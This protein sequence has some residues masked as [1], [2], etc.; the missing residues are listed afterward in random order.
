MERNGL[1]E[2]RHRIF[3]YMLADVACFPHVYYLRSVTSL[4]PVAS[5][6]RCQQK[7]R[8]SLESRWF[9]PFPLSLRRG[10]PARVA[11][12]EDSPYRVS[13][14]FRRGQTASYAAIWV[15]HSRG[16]L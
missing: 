11:A 4:W 10:V 2:R 15:S 12:T 3:V 6:L 8:R 5:V 9:L 7:Q 16:D 13:C 14:T 1:D